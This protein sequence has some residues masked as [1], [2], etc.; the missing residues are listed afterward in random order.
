[1]SSNNKRMTKAL[2]ARSE[3]SFPKIVQ[4]AKSIGRRKCIDSLPEKKGGW[5]Y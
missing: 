1:M 5:I 2:N 4:G 3:E